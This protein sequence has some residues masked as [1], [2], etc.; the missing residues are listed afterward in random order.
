MY[1]FSTE[2]WSRPREEVDALM[3]MF[4]ERIDRE[5]PE[6][7]DEGVRMRFIGRRDGVAAE[8]QRRMDW[9]EEKTD[10][11]ERITLFVAFNYGARAEILDAAAQLRGRGRGGVPPPPLRARD[12]RPRPADPHQRRA[13]RL[14]LPAVAGGL[15]GVRVRRRAVARLHAR[16]L[17]RRA[18]RVRRARRGASGAAEVA[19]RA[20]SASRRLGHPVAGALRD[21]GDRLRAVHRHLR[22]ADLRPRA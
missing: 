11:N 15:L 20:R 14:Q 7:D 2:N 5:T 3:A 22:R 13:A 19:A 1:S 12:A 10:A 21:P 6:L 16:G 17:R 8:L 18:R 4:A 9:A